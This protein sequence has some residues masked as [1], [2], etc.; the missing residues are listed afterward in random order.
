MSNYL[1]LGNLANQEGEFVFGMR[2]AV[3]SDIINLM[4]KTENFHSSWLI[5]MNMGKSMKRIA[6][7]AII[8]LF[9]GIVYAAEGYLIVE[10][11]VNQITGN[12]LIINDPHDRQHK[13][14]HF[15]LS[16]FVQVYDISG[17]ETG[18]SSYADTGYI[19]KARIYVLYGKVEKIR[20]LDM[21]Q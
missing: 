5:T 2:I 7:I 8:L 16:A 6:C 9:C 10:G 19:T 14:Q 12:Y 3:I 13:D 20:I 21:Q 15:P 1:K 11:H 4:S 17:K 18:L